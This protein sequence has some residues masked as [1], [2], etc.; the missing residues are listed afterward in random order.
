M[1]A[2][3]RVSISHELRHEAPHES[4]HRQEPFGFELLR[5]G[6]TYDLVDLAPGP[7]DPIP[8]LKHRYGI[9]SGLDEGAFMALKLS[10]GPHLAAGARSVPVVRMMVGLAAALVPALPGLRAFAWPAAGTLIGREFFASSGAA[11]SDGG[12]FPALGLTAFTPDPD[13]SLHSEGLAFFTGQ[14]LRLEPELSEDRIAATRLA[15]RLV[16]QL[17]GQG[18]IVG[19]EQIV[20]PDGGRLTIKPSAD[21][22]IVQ[23]LRG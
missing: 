1:A 4:G 8:V 20:A 9:E 17:V 13:G 12:A 21:G 11:W 19:P 16:N 15:V 5:E 23:V 7:S 14:E 10:P 3:D 18:R 22:R 2:T 6:L